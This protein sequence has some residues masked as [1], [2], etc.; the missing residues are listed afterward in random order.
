M[1][2]TGPRGDEFTNAHT[3]NPFICTARTHMEMQQGFQSGFEPLED[4]YC[5]THAHHKHT[6]TKYTRHT[7]IDTHTPNT[8][9]ITHTPYTHTHHA[10]K[11]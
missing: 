1:E 10:H 4:T 9:F 2:V 6:Y 8:H 5:E 11:H 3:E 7:H